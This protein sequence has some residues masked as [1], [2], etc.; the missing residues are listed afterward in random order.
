MYEVSEAF[1]KQYAELYDKPV[2][3]YFKDGS[4]RSGLFNDEFF[5]ESAVLIGCEVIKIADIQ[6]M[7]RLEE[8]FGSCM[9]EKDGEAEDQMVRRK[10]IY[11]QFYVCIGTRK[12]GRIKKVS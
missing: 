7:E 2:R 11:E 8:Q 3:V 4:V 12:T 6:K 1:H 5:E 9:G 10:L